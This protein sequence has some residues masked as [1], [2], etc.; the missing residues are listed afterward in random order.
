MDAAVSLEPAGRPPPRKKQSEQHRDYTEHHFKF[1][2]VCVKRT[3]QTSKKRTET[4]ED[5][6]ETQNKRE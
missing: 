6:R 3:S 4:H 2:L 1:A 5:E